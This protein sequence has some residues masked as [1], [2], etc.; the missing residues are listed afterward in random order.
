LE[1]FCRGWLPQEPARAK[2]VLAQ[3]SQQPKRGYILFMAS[4]VAVFAAV[5]V[6]YGL[7]LGNNYVTLV[8][9]PIGVLTAIVVNVLFRKPIQ[10]KPLT[11]KGRRAAGIIAGAN[12]AMVSVLLGT[13]FLINPIIKSG[14]VKLGLWIILLLALF[15]VNNLLLREF[16]KQTGL[17][18]CR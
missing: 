12:V 13:Y 10:N 2:P 11:E 9:A 16:K 5:A 6:M 15:L 7:G 8:A 1:E 17:E 3:A 18:E 14:E 4:F